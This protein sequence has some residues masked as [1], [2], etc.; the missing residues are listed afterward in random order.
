MILEEHMK[1]TIKG[2]YLNN[3]YKQVSTTLLGQSVSD[4]AYQGRS[5]AHQH[6]N[7]GTL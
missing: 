5:F 1:N 6:E 2:N 4:R 3:M 7:V